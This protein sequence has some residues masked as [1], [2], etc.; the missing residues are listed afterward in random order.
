MKFKVSIKLEI[1]HL[2]C[3]FL[4]F[5]AAFPLNAANTVPDSISALLRTIS[6]AKSE[7]NIEQIISC[8]MELSNKYAAKGEWQKAL[9]LM[10]DYTNYHDSLTSRKRSAQVLA[11]AAKEKHEKDSTLQ[12]A[13]TEKIEAIRYAGIKNRELY[14]LLAML[15]LLVAGIL[16]ILIYRYKRIL[17]K[18]KAITII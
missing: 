4:L 5:H 7:G 17:R 1:C 6:V 12:K 14:L 16:A 15:S 9:I 10:K 13:E 8:E 11:I 2:L 18:H 3:M